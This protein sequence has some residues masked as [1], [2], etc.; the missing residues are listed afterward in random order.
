MAIFQSEGNSKNHT[1][2]NAALLGSNILFRTLLWETRFF[3]CFTI[4]WKGNTCFKYFTPTENKRQN[5][6]FEYVFTFLQSRNTDKTFRTTHSKHS[7][8]S[9]CP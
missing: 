6:V 2:T 8:T 5:Y 3:L 7:L 4:L 1:D 9:N